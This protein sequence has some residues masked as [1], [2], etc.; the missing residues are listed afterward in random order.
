PRYSLAAG[1]ADYWLPIRPGSDMAL[2][3][4]WI[5]I[6]ITENL[7]DKE[8]ID[9]YSA[10]FKEL[11]VHVAQ[12]TPEWAEKETEIPA[13]L[14]AETVRELGKN[15][16]AVCVHPGRH[17]TWYGNDVQRSRCLALITALLGAWGREG[18]IFLA[19]NASLPEFE[20]KE[21]PEPAK[22]SLIALCPYPFAGAEG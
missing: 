22:E 17:A 16:P 15:K 13:G 10:G 1:K 21:Y 3:L 20:E 11:A 19:T 14:I 18:G 4:A 2:M 12:Y 5:N 7:Y 9:S 8:Y 6:L